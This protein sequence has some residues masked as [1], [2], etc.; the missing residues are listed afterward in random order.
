MPERLPST[1][2]GRVFERRVVSAPTRKLVCK[3]RSDRTYAHNGVMDFVAVFTRSFQKLFLLR[4]RI[5]KSFNGD[6]I[7]IVEYCRIS[8]QL[9]WSA[10]KAA[11]CVL[12]RNA[13]LDTSSASTH[14]GPVYSLLPRHFLTA[15]ILPD[16]SVRNST[17]LPPLSVTQLRCVVIRLYL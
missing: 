12:S 17:F 4:F 5:P 10:A 15:H 13:L 2:S 11:A 7:V 16:D 14:H 9:Q 6:N 8:R 1:E 3:I